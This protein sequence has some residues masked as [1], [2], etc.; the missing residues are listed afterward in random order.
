MAASR[1]HP[2]K[3][4]ADIIQSRRR[5]LGITQKM[6]AQRSGLSPST[7]T[8]IEQG[9]FAKPTPDC[10]QAIADAIDLPSEELFA[11]AGW[12]TA[13][14]TPAKP[15]VSIICQG[16]PAEVVDKIRDAVDAISTECGTRF[17]LCHRV[18]DTGSRDDRVK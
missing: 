4:L 11:V 1:T 3:Q 13:T 8:R 5:E 7:I 16:V 6:V 10:L 18:T 14:S 2:S 12:L 17:E 9:F 15:R